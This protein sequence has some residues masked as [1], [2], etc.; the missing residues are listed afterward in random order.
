MRTIFQDL[1]YG[2]RM[3]RKNPGF[4][5]I[6]VL[7]LALAIGANTVIF[8]FTNVLVVKPLP[9]KDQ[10]GLGWIFTLDP[11]RGGN[12]GRS[13]LPDYLDLRDSLKSFQALAATS[14][15]TVTMT[16]RGDAM[17]LT[18]NRVSANLFEVWGVTAVQGRGLAAGDDAPGADPVVV[19]SH[20]FWTRQFAGDRAIVGQTLTLDGRAHTIVGVAT[21]SIEFGGLSRIEI[22]TPLTLD[23]GAARDRRLYTIIGRLVPGV[24]VQQADAEVR[25]AA[26]RLEREHPDTNRGWAARVAPTKEAIADADTWV[27][28]ALL[29]TVVGFVLLIAC[30]NIANLVLSRATGRRREL[31]VRTALGASRGRVVRQLVTESLIMGVFGGAL[32]LALAHGG[33]VVIRAAA[34]E[35]FFE[36]VRID[37]NVLLFTA[38]L[39]LTAPLIFSLLPAIQSSRA[40]VSE[41][42]KEGTARAG[43]GVSG[44]RSRSVLVVS[45]LT[46]AMALLIVSGLLVR[47]M[48]AISRTPMGFQPAGVLTLKIDAPEWRYKN[49]A[50]VAQ[51]YDAVLARVS[52][53]PGVQSAAAVD[54]VPVLDGEAVS[55]LDIDGYTPSKPDDRP[56][57]VTSTA[58]ERFFDA[59]GIPILSGRG[60]APQDSA[61][62]LP[63]AL[64]NNQ[65]ARRYWTDPQ[66]AIG[67]QLKVF[68]PG[69][70]PRAVHV[71]GIAGDVKNPDLTGVNPQIYLNAAQVPQRSMALIVR[72]SDPATQMASVRAAV[73]A[74]DPDIAIFSLKTLADAFDEELASSRIL[75]GMFVAFAVL[76]L[77][78][79]AS[80]L[81]G[82]ISYSVSQ[83]AQEIGIRM[84]LGA[85]PSDIRRLVARETVVLVTIGSILGLAGGAAIA[86]A[87]GSVLFGVSPSDPATYATVAAS[88]ILVALVA[89][90]AP[91]RRATRVDPLTALRIE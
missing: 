82:V 43:G 17:R 20:K 13:S 42:L 4:S 2:A 37:R 16:G 29:M 81:Y 22:W 76:A 86:R 65:M 25:E 8:S 30:A 61:G 34:Y 62:A 68:A 46:L 27:I 21:P 89:A 19:L 23:R 58:T 38:V 11:Q 18:T 32:G 3:V 88:L 7:T 67:A 9:I 50:A 56:W 49:D 90:Y 66:R 1:T 77:A 57:A 54:R 79:A 39:A 47:T 41:A 40:D 52:A 63:V 78:L 83:R 45:Q 84:A 73:R 85:V 87:A 48:I 44:R 36:L 69:A 60:F 33:L 91:V 71:I 14:Q 6:I 80:G 24:T 10:D 75:A 31:A 12:R 5:F 15:T 35:P 26:K 59:A 64:I 74:V 72:A 55:N 28:L 70:A 51:Y 53:L